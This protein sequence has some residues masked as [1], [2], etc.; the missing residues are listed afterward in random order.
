MESLPR[1]GWIGFAASLEAKIIASDL[2]KNYSLS[3]E[4]HHFP[5]EALGVQGSFRVQS[6]FLAAVSIKPHPGICGFTVLISRTNLSISHQLDKLQHL[7]IQGMN[8]K[9]TEFHAADL[10]HYE[11]EGQR[12]PTV[13]YGCS[14][15]DKATI[16]VSK[17]SK[18]LTHVFTLV[19]SIFQQRYYMCKL[20]YM[21]MNRLTGVY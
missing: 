9:M 2:K 14:K 18:G 19:P 8:V 13:L 4:V 21:D 7:L 10:A 6:L 12:V 3:E 1:L 15:L 17:G 20:I 11:Y 16:I 5:L